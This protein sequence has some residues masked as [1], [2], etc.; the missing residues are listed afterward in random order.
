M[1]NDKKLIMGAL[2]PRREFL[3]NSLLLTAPLFLGGI[4]LPAFGATSPVYIPP[5]RTR[6]STILN[7][8]DFGAKGDGIADDTRA[9]QNAI[10]ALPLDGGTVTVPAGNYLING[11]IKG[12]KGNLLPVAGH[13][14]RL[15]DRMHLQMDLDAVLVA[16]PTAVDSSFVIYANQ[17]SDVE[18]SGGRIIGE[19]DQHLG[20]TGEWGHGIQVRACNRV[21]IRDIHISKCWGDGICIGGVNQ[22][23]TDVE[24]PSTDISISNIVSTQNR[25]QGLSLGVSKNVQ[26]WDSEF[27]E[28]SGTAPQC[29]IDMEMPKNNYIDNVHIQNCILRNNAAYGAL[30]WKRTSNIV[31]KRCEVYGN[32]YGIVSDG[33]QNGYVG[34]N[35][36]HNN[37]NCGL[38]IRG[39]TVGLQATQNTF[40]QNTLAAARSQVVKFKGWDPVL[41][42]TDVQILEGATGIVFNTNIYR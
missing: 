29:G 27:S 32:S 40:Y 39:W 17:V 25:R 38:L 19:R 16:K 13:S 7:V 11:D 37:I 36:I 20:I 10:A 31:I 21:T 1:S 14:I 8:R 18:I 30:V 12:I 4:S 22:A 24:I 23:G 9:F 26:I 6:G 2:L 35:K 34:L 41:A 33:T 28:T 15:R 42:A 3:Q 5:T